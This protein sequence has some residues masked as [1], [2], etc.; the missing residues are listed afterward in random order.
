MREGGAG[1][2]G[3]RISYLG[4]GPRSR[5]GQPDAEE[6]SLLACTAGTAAIGISSAL[7]VTVL[8]RCRLL[9]CILLF[10][11]SFVL[12]LHGTSSCSPPE[13]LGSSISIHMQLTA[14]MN[15]I[16]VIEQV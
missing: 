14:A 6:N 4:L 9:G 7:F 12:R 5:K 15:M 3:A 2:P 11:R 1:G 16:T 13:K 8:E 10:F